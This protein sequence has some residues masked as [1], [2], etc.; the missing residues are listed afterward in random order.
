MQGPWQPVDGEGDTTTTHGVEMRS[1]T[2]L[3]WP[4]GQ[5]RPEPL[6]CVNL[7]LESFSTYT[8]TLTLAADGRLYWS[9]LAA[10]AGSPE[11]RS[12]PN[13][14]PE[15]VAS[16]LRQDIAKALEQTISSAK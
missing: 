13:V 2:A 16:L 1:E 5:A 7:R 15:A 10:P 11:L 8:A 14:L 12:I 3:T 9:P 4:Y 6:L